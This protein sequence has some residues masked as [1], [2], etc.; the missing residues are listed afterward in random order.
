LVLGNLK[1]EV[2]FRVALA[3]HLAIIKGAHILAELPGQLQR[4]LPRA[5]LQRLLSE[6]VGKFQSQLDQINEVLFEFAKLK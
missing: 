4:L 5:R 6:M 1:F 2:I 3:C